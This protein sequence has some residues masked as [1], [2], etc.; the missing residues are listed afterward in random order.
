MRESVTVT[1]I[2][3]VSPVGAT[4]AEVFDAVCDGR[5]GLS[6]PPA[7]HPVDG[8][9][10]V[11][12]FAPAIDPATVLPGPESRVVDRSIV[13]ALRAAAD[14]LAD[15]GLR[16][17]HDVDPYRVAVVVSGVGG[18]STLADQVLQR[19]Q[20]GRFGVSPYMLPGTLPN[21]GAA[22]IAITHGI[23]GYTSSIG[24]ACAAGAQSVGEGL[25]IL[26][27]GDADVVVAGCAE[28]PLFPAFADAFGNARALARNWADPTAA[29]RPFDRRRNGLVLGEGAGVLVL[30]RAAHAAARGARRHA[31]VLGWGATNDAYHP[32]TPR[33]DGAGA[34]HCMRMAVRDAGLGLDDVGYVNAHG[35]STRAGDAAE[36]A[37]LRDVFGAHP[38]PLSS[39]KGV[40]G[41]MLGVSGVIEAAIGVEALRRGLLP[42]THNLD[43][44]DPGGDVDHVR[45]QARAV[46]VDVVLSNSFGFGGHNVSLV[47]GH[48]ASAG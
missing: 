1:G 40:T 34:A 26:R 16:I 2:G 36:L 47:L 37:A 33:P 31:D 4:A 45:K 19:A 6:R 30:E 35:T 15:A 14:A 9:V 38:P 20:R 48:A 27:A 17:G 43:D 41:H 28:A 46:A 7:G 42:P 21:M 22:R 12:A 5:S 39:T 23:R 25:R 32:T 11:A 13:M 29:S 44:P 3:L 10:D 8:V 18:L 24:T